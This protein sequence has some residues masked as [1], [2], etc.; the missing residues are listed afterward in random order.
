MRCLQDRSA[1]P[2]SSGVVSRA[3][4]RRSLFLL[5]IMAVLVCGLTFAA[6]PAAS[7]TK[8]QTLDP[9]TGALTRA[10]SGSEPAPKGPGAISPSTRRAIPLRTPDPAAL[11]R[12]KE[13]AASRAGG[14]GA[15]APQ[16]LSPL[17][18]A[19]VFGGL[20]QPGM[21]AAQSGG[22]NTPPDTTGAIGPSHY[23]EF[24]NGTGITVYDRNNLN[25]VS[26]PESLEEFIGFPFD[27]VFDPQIQWDPIWGRWIY[28]MDDIEGPT[29]N[30]IAF[31]WSKT[32]NPTPLTTEQPGEEL[33]AG[34]CSYFIETEER[35]DD[36]PKLG[37]GDDGITI[38]TNVF[39]EIEGFLGS[40]LWSIAKLAEPETCPE[41]GAGSIGVTELPLE[42]EDN[43]KAFTPVPA[44]TADSSANSYVV[45]ADSFILSGDSEIM[46][47]HISGAGGGAELVEDGNIAVSVF[48]PPAN[49]PQP[50]TSEVLDSL[51]ARL[52]NAVAVTDPAVGEEA[53][54][55]QH[56]VDGPGGRSVVRWYELLPATQTVRQEGTI[57][58]PTNFVFNAAISPTAQGN[59]AAIHF[60]VG[61]E[62]LSPEMHARSRN[63]GTPLDAMGGDVLLGTSAG[64]AVDFS[65]DI[66]EEE[67]CRWG[68]YAGAS[69]DPLLPGVVWGSNQGLAAPSGT[70]ARWTT[71]NFALSTEAAPAAPTITGTDPPSPANDNEPKVLGIADAGTTVRVYKSSDCSGPI[72]GLGNAATFVSPGLTIAVG[73]NETVQL[74][75]TASDL[76]GGTSACSNSIS[77]TE[78]TPPPPSEESTPPPPAAG[79]PPLA[80]IATAPAPPARGTAVAQKL[81]PVKG[82]KALLRLACRGAG[83]C[84]GSLRLIARVKVGT[85]KGA[86]SSRR[87]VRNI[88]IG[89]TGFSVPARRTKTIRV[90]LN[91]KGTRLVRKA[92]SRGLKVKLR[93]RGVA[94][95]NVRLKQ[96][97]RKRKKGSAGRGATG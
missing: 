43:E 57:S 48:E 97:Q 75:A 6:A 58:D 83:R 60:N 85:G 35:F 33:E 44:N 54:W 72:A 7:A 55:T 40:R 16:S 45:A 1:C 52:T 56:T 49:V 30:Y 92:G 76:I 36:Y 63:A 96:K 68:D 28:A 67:P 3:R 90:R 82:G 8:S 65:C 23:V 39:D 26:G 47:W 50:E 32:A 46:G 27:E 2:A 38:G 29:D 70:F 53:V 20:N 80:P 79:A 88:V 9:Y 89:R 69:P 81:A 59:A 87:R 73:D 10:G 31:G 62:T 66:S 17:P 41:L 11:R 12:A 19:G 22:G 94:N 13:R 84:R 5:P 64:H 74:S 93:G 71:R 61:G 14:G 42:T 25:A 18:K 91:G 95:R 77:Y 24:V 37:H 51:D 86:K 4:G 21:N 78:I 34:W 15:Q